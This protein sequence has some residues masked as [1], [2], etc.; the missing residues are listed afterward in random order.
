M[1]DPLKNN[2]IKILEQK[3]ITLNEENIKKLSDTVD[4]IE[5]ISNKIHENI[6]DVKKTIINSSVHLLTESLM[7]EDISTTLQILTSKKDL[8]YFF[9]YTK[10][11]EELVSNYAKYREDYDTYYPI[12]KEVK[13][14]LYLND[15]KMVNIIREIVNDTNGV[16]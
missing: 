7:R 5:E 8:N 12:L 4:G 13:E 6:T 9:D 14:H 3:G 10:A 16:V 15:Q 11:L 2:V 1:V